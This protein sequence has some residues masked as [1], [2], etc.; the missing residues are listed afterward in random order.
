MDSLGFLVLR[1]SVLLYGTCGALALL[2]GI[3]EPEFIRRCV[4]AHNAHRSRVSPPAASLHS[5]V[6]QV[7][8]GVC[9]SAALFMRGVIRTYNSHC[10]VE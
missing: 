9:Y 10:S 6:R 5:M 7:L 4:L 3:T 2:P 1:I 8:S